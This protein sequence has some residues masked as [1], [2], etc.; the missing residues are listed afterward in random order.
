MSRWTKLSEKDK[1]YIFEVDSKAIP[2]EDKDAL[3]SSKYNVTRRTSRNWRKGSR[4]FV[5][6]KSELESV[7]LRS[8]AVV[9]DPNPGTKVFLITWAQNATPVHKGLW[10]KMLKYAEYRDAEVRVIQGNY[11]NPT[12]IW[13]AQDRTQQY[14]ALPREVL[15]G[16]RVQLHNNL[17]V[18][19]DVPIR[20]TATN[21]L[22]G[23]KEL[24]GEDS[25]I[26]GHP[27]VHMEP[28]P[29]IQGYHKKVV[30]TTGAVTKKN[31]TPSKAG[32]KAEFH[33]TFGFIVVEI[34]G[35]FTHIRNVTA[36]DKT[37]SFTD[38]GIRVDD[39]GIH[40]VTTCKGYVLS[41]LHA[42]VCDEFLVQKSMKMCEILR[43]ETLVV[44][45]AFDFYS[46]SHHHKKN[47]YLLHQKFETGGDDIEREIEET[48]D[49]IEENGIANYNT[50]LIDSNHDRHID[51]WMEEMRD[52]TKDLR[53]AKLYIDLSKLRME[54]KMPDGAFAYLVRQRFKDK[55]HYL[56]MDHS[57][58]IAG[59]ECGMH[60]DV[61]TKGSRGSINQ[62]K[63]LAS[64]S[65]TGHS[66]TPMRKDGA[67][68][69]G[70]MGDENDLEYVQGPN[71]VMCMNVVVHN[72]G[73]AQHIL[74]RK[75]T[76]RF[77]T[78]FDT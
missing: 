65:I 6:G 19:A 9:W 71:N 37:G 53:N 26:V 40:P 12:S 56:P 63:K 29:V 11:R 76:D 28:V 41:D 49:I 33:H 25:L 60:G 74:F 3:I 14:W 17:Q 46:G 24:S 10:E 22:T 62:Y 4:E 72:D 58:K 36:D 23:V 42:S 61:G 54:G 8:T 67:L 43:P 59:F 51:R 34:D 15:M 47:P 13:T 77:T 30:Y 27:R 68:S 7:D 21:P 31:Y 1:K 66:H 50:Y 20:P 44:H 5:T 55:I 78:Q 52:W 48:F 35:E 70:F 2:S 57:L 39:D 73:R 18:A 32:K 16:N 75:E 69:V 45:D 64:K 38:L